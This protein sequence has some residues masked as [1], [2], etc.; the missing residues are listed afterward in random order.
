MIQCSLRRLYTLLLVLF[1]FSVCSFVLEAAI[2]MNHLLRLKNNADSFKIPAFDIMEE[3]ISDSSEDMDKATTIH[4]VLDTLTVEAY[5]DKK[6]PSVKV[7]VAITESMLNVARIKRILF[8]FGTQTSEGRV[9][10]LQ[11]WLSSK[12]SEE[13]VFKNDKNLQTE[14][15][16]ASS[17]K[18]CPFV[19]LGWRR[20]DTCSHVPPVGEYCL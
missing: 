2:H 11:G 8:R 5:L 12:T 7:N 4:R 17:E 20:R 9:L 14:L 16:I 13:I 3:D 19:S 10:I 6:A 18:S 1:A 15:E